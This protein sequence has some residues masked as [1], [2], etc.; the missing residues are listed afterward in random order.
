MSSTQGRSCKQ[1]SEHC[2]EY[3]EDANCKMC[4]TGYVLFKV[5][6]KFECDRE[7]QSK[8][9]LVLLAALVLFGVVI[10]TVGYMK[11]MSYRKEAKKRGL[12][13][14]EAK[15]MD[16]NKKKTVSLKREDLES[17]VNLSVKRKKGEDEEQGKKRKRLFV[18]KKKM[19]IVEQLKFEDRAN[20][21]MLQLQR[22]NSNFSSTKMA[23]T[24]FKDIEEEISEEE[25]KNEEPSIEEHSSI[26][27]SS[28]RTESLLS[29]ETGFKKIDSSKNIMPKSNQSIGKKNYSN[30]SNE[31]T[32]SPLVMRRT[33]SVVSPTKSGKWED[34]EMPST[35]KDEAFSPQRKNSQQSSPVLPLRI[36]QTESSQ[37]YSDTSKKEQELKTT[38]A[39]TKEPTSTNNPSLISNF[40]SRTSPQNNEQDQPQ[41]FEQFFERDPDGNSASSPSMRGY[42]RHGTAGDLKSKLFMNVIEEEMGEYS[43]ESLTHIYKEM[44]KNGGT[45]KKLEFVRRSSVSSRKRRKVN[46]APSISLNEFKL[47]KRVF[48]TPSFDKV[49][50]VD[51]EDKEKLKSSLKRKGSRKGSDLKV[52]FENF[53]DR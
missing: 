1:N 27:K 44:E 7:N 37:N 21:R 9:M 48:K 19:S 3:A 20:A 16:K 25:E 17:Q 39:G 30:T 35:S 5:N 52:S 43:D 49:A 12:K 46:T 42:R 31:E 15:E 33:N 18:E 11:W 50:K 22:Q 36:I 23:A 53:G 28:V 13:K 41:N 4:R 32:L 34:V 24:P 10:G 51:E 40:Q 2:I 38:K 47:E 29:F 26:R 8:E 14:M 6:G 45:P